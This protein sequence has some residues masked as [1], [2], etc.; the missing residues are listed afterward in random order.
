MDPVA[1]WERDNVDGLQP[2]L[3]HDNQSRGDLN[4]KILICFA[5]VTFSLPD[6]ATV[7]SDPC[8][9][10]VDGVRE[11]RSLKWT[12]EAFKE[13][14]SLR[15]HDNHHQKVQLPF[16]LTLSLLCPVWRAD[17]RNGLEEK[18]SLQIT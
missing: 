12:E 9:G 4:E 6:S 3:S 16:A 13:L 17:I 7:S 2:P 1:K 14:S 8:P 5:Q 18:P 10:K 11:D 15:F